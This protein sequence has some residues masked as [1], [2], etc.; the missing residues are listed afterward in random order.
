MLF[1]DPETRVLLRTRPNPLEPGEAFKLQRRKPVGERPRPSPE[2]ITVQRKADKSGTLMVVKQ[3]VSI[4]RVFAHA[5]VTI[6]ISE[7]TLAIELPDGDTKVFRRTTTDVP[8]TIKA[9]RP[10]AVR[11]SG[12]MGAS[13]SD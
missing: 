9:A 4:G 11:N 2:P 10:R 1:F 7:T 13:G 3:R 8:R 6:H 12:A 5:T